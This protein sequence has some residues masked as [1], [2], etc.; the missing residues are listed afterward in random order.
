M[1]VGRQTPCWNRTWI[2]S[3][4]H[5]VLSE[6]PTKRSW[7]NIRTCRDATIRIIKRETFLMAPNKAGKI[8]LDS[9]AV[10]KCSQSLVYF[11]YNLSPARALTWSTIRVFTCV[12]KKTLSGQWSPHQV[13]C[14][15]SLHKS[16][17]R[18]LIKRLYMR[19]CPCMW[20]TRWISLLKTE[21]ILAPR[22]GWR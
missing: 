14:R 3:E 10:T 1:V 22:P 2:L 16:L 4:K 13:I 11:T 12:S 5:Q 9:K 19:N 18:T 8:K 7:L 21:K 17:F 6:I 20:R 15:P